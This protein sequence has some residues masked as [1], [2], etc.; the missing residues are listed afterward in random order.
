MEWCCTREVLKKKK[1]SKKR[2]GKGLERVEKRRKKSEVRK[3]A[4]WNGNLD[5]GSEKRGEG[6]AGI[7]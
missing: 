4:K 7:R 1:V 3:R 5:G 2:G 6:R